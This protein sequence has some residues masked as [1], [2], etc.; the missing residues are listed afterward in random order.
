MFTLYLVYVYCTVQC[1]GSQHPG[2]KLCLPDVILL[3]ASRYNSPL[4]LHFPFRA[5]VA[6]VVFFTMHNHM[7]P[8]IGSHVLSDVTS[9]PE[10]LP[11]PLVNIY[12]V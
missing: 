9:A 12:T 4:V 6:L 2:H 10:D 1:L 8:T 7:Y 5:T 11:C 3:V